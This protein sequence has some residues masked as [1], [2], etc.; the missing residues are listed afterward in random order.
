MN[1][2]PPGVISNGQCLD[3][4]KPV[5]PVMVQ[6]DKYCGVFLKCAFYGEDF[7]LTNVKGL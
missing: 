7:K 5:S 1:N 2:K 6:I 4:Q 3:F